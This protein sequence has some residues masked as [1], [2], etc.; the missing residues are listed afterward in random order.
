VTPP[1]PNKESDHEEPDHEEAT[2]E[3][4]SRHI[5]PEQPTGRLLELGVDSLVQVSASSV[6][7]GEGSL[8][9]YVHKQEENDTSPNANQPTDRGGE[10]ADAALSKIAETSLWQAA[11]VRLRLILSAEDFNGVVRYAALLAYDAAAGTAVLCLPNAFLCRQITTRLANP[12][13]A[14]LSQISGRP[15]QVHAVVQPAGK[16]AARPRTPATQQPPQAALLRPANDR[17]TATGRSRR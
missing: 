5:P 17:R 16:E 15:V 3:T 10:S 13:A 11:Q 9:G 4:G 1:S 6:L 8:K 7:V 2:R 12:I 14:V